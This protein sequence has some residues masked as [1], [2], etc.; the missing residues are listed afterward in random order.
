MPN[1]YGFEEVPY[2]KTMH[3]GTRTTNT[4]FGV[5]PC[6]SCLVVKKSLSKPLVAGIKV[7]LV[8]ISSKNLSVLNAFVHCNV[9]CTHHGF[10]MQLGSQAHVG[11]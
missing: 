3:A 9:M 6:L 4:L 2:I 5:G 11:L 7:L 1:A 10:Y 8:L